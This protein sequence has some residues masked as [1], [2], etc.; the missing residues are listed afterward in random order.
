[1]SDLLTPFE[2]QQTVLGWDRVDAFTALCW[3]KEMYP[4]AFDAAAAAVGR[5]HGHR[6][7]GDTLAYALVREVGR[8]QG[9]DNR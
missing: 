6:A 4:E 1:M 8:E 9:E 3:I 5:V 2:R 7:V